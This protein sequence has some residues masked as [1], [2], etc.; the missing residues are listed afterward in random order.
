MYWRK[1]VYTNVSPF[2]L[3]TVKTDYHYVC[4]RLGRVYLNLAE[5]YL[6]KGDVPDAVAAFNQT[7]TV[8]G[9]LPPSVASNLADAWT[10]YKR[11]R[12]VDLTEENDYYYSLLR[13]G[14][15]GGPANSNIAPGG[16]I[17]GLTEPVRV[18]DI[19]RDRKGFV[20]VTGPF[21]NA[22]DQRKFDPGRRYLLPIA[23][24]YIDN[25][26]GFGPQN[27]GW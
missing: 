26:P 3:N 16:T 23:Q 25:N 21:S 19:T 11:E 12:R 22:Y 27:P 1:G 17:P 18:M 14:R 7:R 5:A 6:L 2:Y 20:I 15:Y 10:D 4:M 8:H 9:Q 24:S 13:W